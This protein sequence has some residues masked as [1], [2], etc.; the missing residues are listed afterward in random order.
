MLKERGVHD[1]PVHAE[2]GSGF[3]DNPALFGDR[4]PSSVRSRVVSL[5]RA[6]TAGS[7]SVNEARGKA[8][9][10]RAIGLDRVHH[11]AAECVRHDS[12]DRESA[13]VEKT[14]GVRYQIVLSILNVRRL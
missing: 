4:D 2:V 10:C 5:E 8:V 14:R 6:R 13:Q 1:G 11:P 7:D 3:G 9:P 12:V